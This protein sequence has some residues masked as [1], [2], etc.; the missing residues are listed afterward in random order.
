MPRPSKFSINQ[1][2]E[3]ALALVDK[4]GL[5]GLSMRSLADSLGTGAM[6]IYNYVSDRAELE[7]LLVDAVMLEAEWQE[8]FREDWRDEV[9]EIAIA[10]WKVARKHPNVIPLLLTRRSFS[11]AFLNPTEF[12][13]R[14]LA[15]G[16][17]SGEE[18]LIAFRTVSGFSMGIAQAELAGPLSFSN[19]ETAKEV[20]S[21]FKTLPQEKYPRL[22]E[23]AT[24]ASK[25]DPGKEFVAGLNIIL[26]GLT[27]Q[28]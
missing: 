22:I 5:S 12:L 24:A 14:A 16:G 23:I 10:F 1:L 20:I 15:R 19:E 11:E 2:R 13:L 6:T 4:E 18:L 27:K 26:S 3:A 8:T 9:R 7:S 21:R 25:S 17:R 28:V